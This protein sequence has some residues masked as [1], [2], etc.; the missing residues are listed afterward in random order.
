MS[1]TPTNSMAAILS[2]LVLVVFWLAIIFGLLGAVVIGVGML[3][4]MSGGVVTLPFGEALAEGVS[5]GQLLTV[6]I[7]LVVF[8][9]GIAYVCSQ[10]R[11]ILTTL[12]AGD[13]FVPDNGPRL[14]RIALALG[15]IEV[16]RNV[17]VIGFGAAGA[18]GE[19]VSGTIRFNPALW[20]AVIVLFIL[21]QVFKEGT[22]LRE[23]EKMT[24]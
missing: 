20:G 24:I 1:D 8:A 6:L 12:A 3:G 10:L 22:R 15:M 19:G 23:E 9:V 18:L 14:M 13:P 7:G 4:A 2:V 5:P 16:I 21:A 11:R 17:L